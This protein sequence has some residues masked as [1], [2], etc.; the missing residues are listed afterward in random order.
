MTT[1]LTLVGQLQNRKIIFGAIDFFV[2]RPGNI[3]GP[4]DSSGLEDKE[5]ALA[6]LSAG[7]RGTIVVGAD[8]GGRRTVARI[9]AVLE[10]GAG[11]KVGGTATA[12]YV[13]FA[14]NGREGGCA[15]R[16]PHGWFLVLD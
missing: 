5:D 12:V 2:R 13:K 10:T 4:T 11:F 1:A 15:W 6:F 7:A 14:V 8:A 16:R 3:A 9:V